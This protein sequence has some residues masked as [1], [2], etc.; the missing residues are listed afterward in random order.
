MAT[1]PKSCLRITS[2]LADVSFSIAQSCVFLRPLSVKSLGSHDILGLYLPPVQ[3]PRL[4]WFPRMRELNVAETADAWPPPPPPTPLLLFVSS[5]C[6]ISTMSLP[7][8]VCIREHQSLTCA[9]YLPSASMVTIIIISNAIS[10]LSTPWSFPVYHLT[11][12]LRKTRHLSLPLSHIAY[13]S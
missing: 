2:L 8:T 11:A 12:H 6:S 3:L 7:A 4:G 10:S 9:S 1:R 13:R 5:L